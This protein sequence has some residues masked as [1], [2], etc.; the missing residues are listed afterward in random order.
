M[1]AAT[2][3]T[4][5]PKTDTPKTDEPKP[6]AAKSRRT[7]APRRSISIAADPL[8]TA[9]AT[10]AVPEPPQE[11]EV[12]P[13]TK[14]RRAG[15]GRSKSSTPADPPMIDPGLRAGEE[16]WDEETF[17]LTANIPKSLQRRINGLVI[18]S[19]MYGLDGTAPEEINS[20]TDF[21]RISAHE[22]LQYFEER[23]NGGKPFPAPRSLPRGRR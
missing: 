23:L 20:L 21:V 16:S 19:Q 1:N 18:H 12:E 3:K 17:K 8:D 9:P 7:A 15:S 11:I 13:T 10:A 6:E 5:T 14:S 4:A 2:P 22:K